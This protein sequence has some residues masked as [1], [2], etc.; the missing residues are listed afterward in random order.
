MKILAIDTTSSAASVALIDSEKLIGEY[1][2]NAKLTHLQKLMPMIEQ[3]LIHCEES[4]ENIE[5]IAVSEG[6][7]SFT[8]I[9]IGVATAKTLSQVGDIPIIAVPTLMAMAY[10]IPFYSGII[11][12][13]FDARRNQVYSA[14][15]RWEGDICKEVIKADAYSID[16]ITE[17]LKTFE[18]VIFLGDGVNAYKNSILSILPNAKFAPPYLKTQ[19]ASSVAQLGLKMA[20]EKKL[21]NCY[22]MKPEYLRKPEA[23]RNLENK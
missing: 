10:N 11:C 7:G 3:L 15:Y 2:S 5:A 21:L 6:P 20:S 19:K 1:T 18:D 14:A 16:E 23:E 8:G 17:A 12:P 9:R 13:I 4:F 22:E